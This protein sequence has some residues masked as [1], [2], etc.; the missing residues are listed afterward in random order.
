MP[1]WPERI[2]A[3]TP[4]LTP[5]NSQ[6]HVIA[7]T[8]TRNT[9]CDISTLRQYFERQTSNW[10]IVRRPPCCSPS[11]DVCMTI[12]LR[13]V[14]TAFLVAF[15]RRCRLV[16]RPIR[17]SNIACSAWNCCSFADLSGRQS[18][19]YQRPH[20][21]LVDKPSRGHVLNY[22]LSVWSVHDHLDKSEVGFYGIS[23][24]TYERTHAS[25]DDEMTSLRD[26]AGIFVFQSFSSH[27]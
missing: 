16:R 12:L 4:V 9:E 15:T 18:P 10:S 26:S 13:L 1:R 27:A 2:D 5:K 21:A 3:G 17:Y 25:R 14:L 8:A 19:G 23:A 6:M 24:G 20:E 7:S 22:V 11:A